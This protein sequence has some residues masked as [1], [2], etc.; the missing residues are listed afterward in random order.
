MSRSAPQPT[1]VSCL[2]ISRTPALL[3]RL[4]PSLAAARSFWHPGDEVL[5]SWNGPVDAE[6]SIDVALGPCPDGQPAFR[7]AQRCAYHFAGNMNALAEQASGDLLVLLNDDLI[8]DPGSLDRAIQVLQTHPQ[9]G[10]VGGRL[11]SSSG[12]LTHA[13][14]LFSN[15]HVPYNR[16]RP[17][18]LGPL[19]PLDAL[20]LHESGPMPAV[21]G[22]LM[23]MQ[24]RDFLALRLH[25]QFRVCGEDIALCLDLWTQ[26]DKHPYYASDVTAIH[27]EKTTRGNTVDHDDIQH[28]ASYAAA[29]IPSHPGLQATG[30]RWAC[31]EGEV[32][33]QLAQR[34]RHELEQEQARARVASEAAEQE[35]AERERNWERQRQLLDGRIAALD[36]QVERAETTIRAMQ[37]SSSWQLTAPLRLVGDKLKPSAPADGETPADASDAAAVQAFALP[38]ISSDEDD[39]RPEAAAEEP[40]QPNLIFDGLILGQ[41]NRAAVSRGGIYRY[42]SELLVALSRDGH[43]ARLLPYCPDP[44]LAGSV[45]QE[46]QAL[47]QRYGVALRPTQEAQSAIAKRQAPA[48]PVPPAPLKRLVRPLYRRLVHSPLMR[49]QAER[50]LQATLASCRSGNT[51]FHTPFQSVPQ[52]VR[53]SGL[54]AVVVT[55]HD[56]LP[57]IHPEFFTDETIGQFDALLAQLLPSDHV[58]CVS[59]STRQDFLRCHPDTPPEQVHVTPL[60]ASPELEPVQNPATLAAMRQQLGLQADEQ[61]ILSLCT[62]EPRKN[63]TTLI[64]AFE[65]L[66]RR[67][68]GS[69]LKLVLAGSLG[70]K[71]TALTEQL[72]TSAAANAIVVS[73]HIPDAQLA[74]LYSLAD[75]FVYPSVYEGFGLP[76][77]EAMQCGTPVIVG[78]TSSLPEVVGNAA[79]LVDPRSTAELQA[80]LSDLLGS[81]EQREALRQAGLHQAALFSWSRTAQQTA[82]IYRS[83]LESH[84]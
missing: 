52:E 71:T 18:D 36:A 83:I 39:A 79:H 50:Q 20:P 6:A 26:L 46:L 75:V 10:V 1:S 9:V 37:A 22:A 21:T 31:Q 35:R 28:L 57:R 60:A 3:N 63:L 11:R 42:A 49:G 62:L 55:V 72:R 74:C 16:Y 45:Q 24:R 41:A 76:P 13:G 53:R 44:L 66:W 14:L 68:D 67:S 80:A 59:E 8:L 5:C 40:A 43:L 2:V 32:M 7:I 30:R 65:Q 48:W 84:S 47:E 27:D 23:V 34:L 64:E 4:L 19:I 54:Q 38:S 70:W 51:V 81:P 77:L 61:V 69:K 73:G 33:W 78:N 25:E 12:L 29:R 17:D 15:A 58:I 82:A 56:M